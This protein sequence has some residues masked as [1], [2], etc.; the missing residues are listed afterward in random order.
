MLAREVRHQVAERSRELGA[1]LARSDVGTVHRDLKPANVLLSG[2]PSAPVA[3]IS[4]FGI[5]RFGVID[6]R[7]SVDPNANTLGAS[8]AARGG[9]LTGTGVILGTPL[10][11]APE[12]VRGGHTVDAA[13]DIW[14]LGVLAYE[15]LAGTAPFPIPAPVLVMA[16]QPIPAPPPLS[17][18]RVA[19][20]LAALLARCLAVDPTER[21]RARELLN[22]LG[23]AAP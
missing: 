20:E 14:A 8:P 1:V 19:P 12:S 21:P 23:R 11:M 16:D 7:S 6:E 3:K 17:P 5:S 9:A 18:T 22:G 10:Y 13:A 2:D 15:L 4:D